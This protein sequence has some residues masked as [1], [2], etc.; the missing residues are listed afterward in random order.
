MGRDGDGTKWDGTGENHAC[1]RGMRHHN[2]KT[3]RRGVGLAPE[4]G[5]ADASGQTPAGGYAG[6]QPLFRHQCW[7]L[8]SIV[9]M[10][11]PGDDTKTK[12]KNRNDTIG[13]NAFLPGTWYPTPALAFFFSRHFHFPAQLVGGLTLQ[14][15]LLDKVV[16][17]TGVFFSLPSCISKIKKC[18]R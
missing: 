10:L 13:A 14:K 2:T 15:G 12:T 17:V 3:Q 16:V 4:Q 6:T 8:A 11:S 18:E 1:E 5:D 7:R 9:N